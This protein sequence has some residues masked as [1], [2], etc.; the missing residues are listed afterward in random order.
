M[1]VNVQRA[2]EIKTLLQSDDATAF[3]YRYNI[4]GL[5]DISDNWENLNEEQKREIMWILMVHIRWHMESVFVFTL[6]EKWQR[7]IQ[8]FILF[9]HK[10]RDPQ[11]MICLFYLLGITPQ[12]FFTLSPD[13]ILSQGTHPQD[14]LEFV[15]KHSP[16]VFHSNNTM[17]Y[18]WLVK[19]GW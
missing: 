7:A 1:F 17:F 16:R 6:P 15:K 5:R 13:Q 18:D 11:I 10:L 19:V 4:L 3:L 8:K 12:S 14:I 9:T 2:A